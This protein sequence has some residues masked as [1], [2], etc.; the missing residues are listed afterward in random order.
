MAMTTTTWLRQQHMLSPSPS[1]AGTQASFHKRNVCKRTSWLYTAWCDGDKNNGTDKR[2]AS[3]TKLC[4]ISYWTKSF[5]ISYHRCAIATKHGCDNNICCQ[6]APHLFN[7]TLCDGNNKQIGTIWYAGTL[8]NHIALR[9]G[10]DSSYVLRDGD[11]NNKSGYDNIICCQQAPLPFFIN[12]QDGNNKRYNIMCKYMA[13]HHGND[14]LYWVVRWQWW[15]QQR[16]WR[17]MIIT[18]NSL[19]VSAPLKSRESDDEVHIATTQRQN[20]CQQI[21]HVHCVI[22]RHDNQLQTST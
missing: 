13:L 3:I 5:F 19:C 8:Y 6:Q 11:G 15:Q 21:D 12:S 2:E 4:F 1:C 7:I 17:T 14:L 10:N 18:D 16:Q 20:K 22:H 9:D